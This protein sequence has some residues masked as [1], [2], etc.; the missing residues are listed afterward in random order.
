[1]QGDT[2]LSAARAAA[3]PALPEAEAACDVLVVGSGAAG[4]RAA[5]AAAEAGARALIVT[6]GSRLYSGASAS[7]NFSYCASFGYF[8]AEDSA[9][10]YARDILASGRGLA[11]PALARLLGEQA[12]AEAD[13]VG[14][15]GVPW[16]RGADGRYDLATFGGHAFPRAIHVGLRTGK[17]V[18]VT[19]GRRAAALGVAVQDYTVALEVLRDATGVR[20]LLAL[21]LRHGRLVRIAAPVVVLATGG[22]VAMYALHTNPDEL[23]GDGHALAYAAG[24]SLV[25]CEFIQSY[26]TVLVA[27]AAARGLHYPTGR[28]LGFG[29]ELLNAQGEAFFHRYSTLPIQQATRDEL[30]R[31]I[32]LEI[33]GGRGTPAGGVLVDARR[34]APATLR[35]VHFEAY[36]R[37]LGLDVGAEP[38]Q[39]APTPHFSLGGVRIDAEGRTDLAGLFAA[40]E[41]AGGLHGANRLTG[42]AL[43]ETLV[44]G[45][46]AGRAAAAHAARAARPP[47]PDGGAAWISALRAALA[48]RAD[49]TTPHVGTAIARLRAAMQA[50]AGVVK[51]AGSLAATLTELDAI[52]REA[53]PALGARQSNPRLNWELLRIVELRHMLVAAR[54]HCVAALA[55]EESRGAHLRLDYPQADDARFGHRLVMR[56]DLTDPQPEAGGPRP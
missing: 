12:G 17:Q 40:G 50:G 24:A 6:K 28:L 55:R 13:R 47:A 33:A 37:D 38:Q 39:V 51:S 19:L 30:A 7:A 8:G 25:D 34:V 53:M 48:P 10:T 15:W 29:A 11:D 52:E 35:D 9:E 46:A 22:N 3:G 43:P 44:F 20:G 5:I 42:V 31:A 56:R 4:F 23:T 32:A 45:A 16:R 1:M 14:A 26:P 49:A 2:A 41:V 21:D 36:F 27:P 18:M 54:L